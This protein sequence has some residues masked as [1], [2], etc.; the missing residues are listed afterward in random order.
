VDDS[1]PNLVHKTL[2]HCELQTAIGIMQNCK[3]NLR[4]VILTHMSKGSTMDKERAL[5][6]IKTS[7]PEYIEVVFA[8]ENTVEDISEIPF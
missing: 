5:K 7:I 1:L 3:K 4:K 2:G 8:K 6:E